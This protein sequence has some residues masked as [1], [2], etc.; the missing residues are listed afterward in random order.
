MPTPIPAWPCVALLAL[1]ACGTERWTA[2]LSSAAESPITLSKVT[3]RMTTAARLGGGTVRLDGD[4]AKNSVSFELELMVRERLPEG[5]VLGSRSACLV[6]G[7]VWA[8]PFIGQAGLDLARIGE[9]ITSHTS[10]FMPGPLAD[11]P[12]VVCEV[13]LRVQ[14]G[15]VGPD[16]VELVP[17]EI[18][19]FCWTRA[20]GL[21]DRACNDAE[22]V[23]PIPDAPLVAG[24]LR[25]SW[26]RDAAGAPSLTMAARVTVGTEHGTGD[27]TA[28]AACIT[29]EGPPQQSYFSTLAGLRDFRAGESLEIGGV[30]FTGRGFAG[31]R[32]T[33]ELRH[34]PDPQY[35]PKRHEAV[36]SFC[37]AGDVVT[38]GACEGL[39]PG[40]AFVRIAD[41]QATIERGS[42]REGPYPL[43]P[44]PSVDTWNAVV[45]SVLA[46]H[47]EGVVIAAPAELEHA[48]AVALADT[49]KTA[50]LDLALRVEG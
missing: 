21:A 30:A 40:P 20:G 6:D 34:R 49:A 13:T 25:A 28:A 38:E 41:E 5:A 32:C 47:D 3:A 22:L 10:Q 18:G 9:P 15:R 33:I 8:T 24:P 14:N 16:I 44:A 36:A 46:T 7:T 31:E 23:R 42:H 12:P 45:A 19:R 17:I 4:S 43:G 27:L 39:A 2:E 26:H 1:V 50:G 35:Y 48:R 29:G 11:G 37:V